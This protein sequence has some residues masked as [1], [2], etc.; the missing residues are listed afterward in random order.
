MAES[1]KDHDDAGAAPRLT[2][3]EEIAN[4]RLHS[5]LTDHILAYYTQPGTLANL[6]MIATGAIWLVLAPNT[7]NLPGATVEVALALHIVLSCV[8]L[9]IML[10][11]AKA[12]EQRREFAIE[13][14]EKLFPT[15]EAMGK[16]V[17]HQI[18]T[19][20]LKKTRIGARWP[21]ATIPL[22]GV[23][24]SL[25]IAVEQWPNLE[26]QQLVCEQRWNQLVQATDRV[27]LERARYLL[28]KAGCDLRSNLVKSMP[29]TP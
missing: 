23:C 2:L 8:V 26:R 16:S 21:W 9:T 29:T 6:F 22:I 28:D 20:L 17:A 3:A 13:I 19:G 7:F 27:Q 5:R 18:S 14:G 12:I 24:G 10:S 1:H 4:Y 15:I 25:I 11:M